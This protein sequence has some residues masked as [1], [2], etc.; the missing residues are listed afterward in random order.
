VGRQA[1]GVGLAGM[2]APFGLALLLM[3]ALGRPTNEALFVGVALT[4][5][6]VGITARVLSDLGYL[7]TR[8]ARIILG[9]AVLDDILG[10]LVLATVSSMAAGSVSIPEIL[11]LLVEAVAFLVIAVVV[12]RPA[13][14]RLSPR[15][16]RLA[17]GSSG[18]PLF[19]V[20][21]ALCF[22]FSALASVIGLAAI[23]GAFFAGIIFAEIRE[24]SEVRRSMAP[25]YELLVPIFFVLMGTRVDV[26]RLL[27][28]E[29]LPVGLLI[30]VIAIIGKL[31]ACGLSAYRM[32]WRDAL[33]VGVG[34]TPRGEVGIVVALIGLSRGVISSDV[35]S[36]VILMSV[37][38][39]LFAPS[40]LRILLVPPATAPSPPSP[41]TRTEGVG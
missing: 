19:A 6:S 30:T 41:P 36:Q 38:T 18:N 34:M 2:V 39:S 17:A 3:K 27:S 9:A 23:I 7:G 20:A 25:I 28:A 33:A 8:V 15:L 40:L 31:G 11:V 12:G 14:R 26:H 16:S 37:L 13:M 24:A 5:T 4:A 21:I 32:G 22:A 29:V 1:A 10:M 35:Y